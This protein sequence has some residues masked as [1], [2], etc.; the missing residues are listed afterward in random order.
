MF[1]APT[2]QFRDYQILLFKRCIYFYLLKLTKDQCQI[3][4]LGAGYDT[5]YWRL[6]EEGLSIS[7]YIEIDF[8]KVTKH[9]CHIIRTTQTLNNNLKAGEAMKLQMKYLYLHIYSVKMSLNQ[10]LF[11]TFIIYFESQLSYSFSRH[12]GRPQKIIQ[13]GAKPKRATIFS[14]KGRPIF[15]R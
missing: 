6:K 12:H 5:L 4:N 8:P 9:K 14:S 7:N 13:G 1:L 15:L 11:Q 2:F 10:Y 3:I